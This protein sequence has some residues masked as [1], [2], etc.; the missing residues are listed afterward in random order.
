MKIR[1]LK[2]AMLAATAAALVL[3]L[4]AC[5]TG[6]GGG[7]N[8]GYG[9]GGSGG[10]SGGGGVYVDPYKKAWFDVYGTRCISNGYPMSGCNFY[11]DGTKIR[12]SA[13]PYYSSMTLY[14]DYWTYTDSYGYRRNFQGY[15]WL[16]NTGILF[17]DS[18]NALNEMDDESAQSSD[19]ISLAAEKEAR[20]SK[21]VGKAFAQKYALAEEAGVSIAKTLQDWA[22]LG[23]DRAR[24][25]GDVA[26]FSK[27]LYGVSLDKAKD[28]LVDAVKGNQDSLAE[29]NVDVAAHWGTSPETSKEILGKWYK[30]ELSQLGVK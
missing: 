1:H 14:F 25:N 8:G 26:D 5:D 10:G 28:A 21:S 4:S 23:R 15:A 6:G 20:V 9:G 22:V 3:T 16:S 27:R 24:T 30:D 2:S 13:D 12:S 18:G 29:L 17:D 7:S 11:A 19:V